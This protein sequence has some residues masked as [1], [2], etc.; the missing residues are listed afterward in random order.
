MRQFKFRAW[1][2]VSKE[3]ISPD[4]VVAH[5]IPVK[6]TDAGFRLESF[7]R[8]MQSTG[9]KDENGKEI[10]EG[11]ILKV[12]FYEG[13]NRRFR[14]EIVEFG[15]YDAE[16]YGEYVGYIKYDS[17]NVEVIGNIFENPELICEHKIV[18]INNKCALCGLDLNEKEAKTNE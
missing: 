3:M 17:K 10:Y 18:T 13:R 12:R 16:E 1:D 15:E 5:R 8:L 14:T 11:D 2:S 9:L 7:F 4:R 6:T